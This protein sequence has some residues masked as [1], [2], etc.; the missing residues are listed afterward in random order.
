MRTISPLAGR[1]VFCLLVP[2]VIGVFPASARQTIVTGSVSSVVDYSSR[3]YK[4]G[5]SMNPD[6]GDRQK[7]GIQ[8]EVLIVSKDVRDFL[9]LRYSPTLSYD[10]VVEDNEVDH[11]LDIQGERWLSQFWSVSVSESYIRSDDPG[12]PTR[13]Q[14][15]DPFAGSG[16]QAQPT[17][18]ELSRDMNGRKYWTNT[19]GLRTS[20]AYDKDSRIAGGYTYSVLRNDESGEG[21][22]D[23]DRHSFDANLTHGFTPNWQANMGVN[24]TRGVYD[25]TQG[26]AASSTATGTPDLDQYG[27]HV[28]VNFIR[29][30]HDFYSL[31][32]S[33][34]ESRYDGDTRPD[35]E[36]H[37]WSLGWDHAFDSRT[38]MALGAG[39]SYSRIQGLDGTWGYNAYATLTRTYQ[40]AALSLEL[41][42]VYENNNFTGSAADSGLTDTYKARASFS[43]RH[44]QNLAFDAYGG[45]RLESNFDPQGIYQAAA[46]GGA[47]G[48][49]KTGDNSYDKNIYEVGIGCTYTFGRWYTAGLRYSYYV[50][51]G[52]LDVDQYTDH[53]ILFTLR[54][55]HELWRW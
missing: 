8:P 5:D 38:R 10:F 29:T 30:P 43:Y 15:H 52:D 19:A 50:S 46:G 3:S 32:Y 9:S 1:T 55:S 7:I 22:E 24:Y 48:T 39:P 49:K 37:S 47:G 6:D 2:L 14:P 13:D 28:G 53:Q 4:H 40:H 12:T 11:Q 23:Y 25:R 20:Y 27:F 35:N 16:G 31:N 33:L 45:Y 26:L 54:A 18:P 36:T 51:D 41:S 34:N 17:N 42:K 21:Y 44:T